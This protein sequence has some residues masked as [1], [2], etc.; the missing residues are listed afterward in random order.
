M[1]GASFLAY[2]KRVFK[3][4]DKDTE[5]YEAT[6]DVISDIRLQLKT[7]DS[8]EEA[9]IAGISTLGNYRI[10][11]PSDF[12]HI[13]GNITIVDESNGYTSV[14]NKI[15]KNTYDEKYSD[16][17]NA[18]LSQVDYALPTEFCVYAEQIY[19]GPVPDK[20]T[21]K[22][23][24]NYTTEYT[25]EV[26]ALTDP[27]PFAD[28]YRSTLRSGVLAEL[29]SGLEF[30]DEA[31]YWK[32]LYNEGLMKIKMNDDDNISNKEGVAYCGI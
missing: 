9:Y 24:I 21:Y 13:I 15:S 18:T 4:T 31:S 23:Y 17:L 6:T 14:L 11:L 1:D 22:Y 32:G 7:E 27:L 25:T 26:T 12:G 2:V 19:I 8:K 30:F 10:A 28:K 16:R 3:R 5:I 20:I 29:Y